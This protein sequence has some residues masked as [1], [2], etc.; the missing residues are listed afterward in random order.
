MRIFRATD[1]QT[2]RSTGVEFSPDSGQPADTGTDGPRPTAPPRASLRSTWTPIAILLLVGS[3][4]GIAFAPGH[5]SNDS[6]TQIAQIRAGEYTNWHAPA[7]QVLWAPFYRIGFGPGWLVLA[8]GWSFAVGSYLVARS[9]L[10]RRAALVLSSLVTL[11]PMV[12]GYLGVVSRDTW[13]TVGFVSAIGWQLAAGRWTGR[14][15]NLAIAVSIAY[16]WLMVGARQNAIPIAFIIGLG[17]TPLVIERV[18]TVSKVP[19]NTDHHPAMGHSRPLGDAPSADTL[20]IRWVV[21]AGIVATAT[22]GGGVIGSQRLLNAAM[23]VED[24]NLEQAVALYDLTIMSRR[25]DRVLLPDSVRLVDELE[26]YDTPRPWYHMDPILF[27]PRPLAFLPIGEPEV[28][29]DLLATWRKVITDEPV[30]YFREKWRIWTRQIGW[31]GNTAW[32]VHPVIDPNDFGYRPYLPFV[33]RVATSYARWGA[34]N[35]DLDG[36]LVHK[37]WVYLVA[38]LLVFVVPGLRRLRLLAISSACYAATIFVGGMGVQY[39]WVLPNV[40]AGLLIG[41]CAICLALQRL[42]TT[43]IA[44]T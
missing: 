27:G 39:R 18:L 14:T 38:H 25:L 1:P 3:V 20:G 5:M 13:F 7:L 26:A 33:D 41:G 19:E 37:A 34:A 17:F 28:T 44:T 24:V 31:S 23:D 43:R 2:P 4:P 15:R 32:I 22:I 29:N 40:V 36:G 30:G 12:F 16:I 11:C 21:L 6:L 9:V 8:V 35:A 10:R 42:A